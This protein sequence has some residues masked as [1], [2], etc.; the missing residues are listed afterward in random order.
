[1]RPCWIKLS[2]SYKKKIIM[3]SSVHKYKSNVNIDALK[4]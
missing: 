4:M 3:K 1:M 2:I